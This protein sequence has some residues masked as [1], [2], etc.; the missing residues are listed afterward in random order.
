MMAAPQ[1]ETG[2]KVTE[3]ARWERDEEEKNIV[4]N[5]AL[6]FAAV[7][8]P[9]WSVGGEEKYQGYRRITYTVVPMV[10]SPSLTLLCMFLPLAFDRAHNTNTW[11]WQKVRGPQTACRNAPT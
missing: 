4:V 1:S 5:L 11:A 6:F 9:Y 7:H 10:G 3:Q 2:E 8:E